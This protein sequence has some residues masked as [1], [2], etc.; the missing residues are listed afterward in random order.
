MVPQQTITWKP[1][2]ELLVEK[3]L[4]T[5]DELDDALEEQALT[6]ERLGAILI[7]RRIVASAVVT[8]V[9]AEQVGVELETEHGFGSGLF[10]RIAELNGNAEDELDGSAALSE[11]AGLM[12]IGVPP[13]P[14]IG[15]PAL[16]VAD[17]LDRLRNELASE[18]KRRR[19]LEAELRKLR[20]PKPPAKPTGPA[21]KA[22]PKPAPGKTARASAKISPARPKPAKAKTVKPT[23]GAKRSSRTA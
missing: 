19:V 14:E 9:L 21:A 12:L 4:L 7:G 15:R 13:M 2:G 23:A 20:K 3:R 16:V 8:T 17:E 11:G 10:S 5:V 1:L 6:G 22:K 18:R